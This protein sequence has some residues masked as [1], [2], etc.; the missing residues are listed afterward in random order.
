MSAL[1]PQEN[2]N[3]NIV[4]LEILVRLQGRILENSLEGKEKG[5]PHFPPIRRPGYGCLGLA[6]SVT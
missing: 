3:L 6:V 1:Y 2:D 4:Q 5:C